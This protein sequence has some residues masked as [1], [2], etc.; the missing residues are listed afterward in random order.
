MACLLTEDQRMKTIF[1]AL[2]PWLALFLLAPP[3]IGSERGETTG[4]ILIRGTVD[5]VCEVAVFDSDADLDLVE[6]GGSVRVGTVTETCNSP[7]GYVVSFKSANGGFMSGPLETRSLYSIHYDSLQNASL[8]RAQGIRRDEPF[9]R[10]TH[11]L[12]VRVEAGDDLPAG[13]YSD[14]LIVEIAAP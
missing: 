1:A 6:G 8:A 10:F 2:M 5:E 9:W 13:R 12:S 14:R 7:E 3:A 11:D 4:Q